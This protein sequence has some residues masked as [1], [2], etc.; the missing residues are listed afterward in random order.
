[1]HDHIPDYSLREEIKIFCVLDKIL[2]NK[3]EWKPHKLMGDNKIPEVR[4][5]L[6]P[7]KQKRAKR[8]K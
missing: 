1:M 8:R 3:D 7:Y 5:L 4:F 6:P 2:D